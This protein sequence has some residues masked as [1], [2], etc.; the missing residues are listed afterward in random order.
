MN[1]KVDELM[2]KRVV[3]T[4]PHAT[5]GHVQGMLKRNRVGAVPVV[6][7]DGEP[8]GIVSATD[9]SPDLNPASPVS[10]IMTGD[11][12]RVFNLFYRHAWRDDTVGG[13]IGW[14]KVSGG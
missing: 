12:L 7:G 2:T 5:V 6:N 9:L 3:T 11:A 10:S 13:S 1:V 14:T 4:E 8:I